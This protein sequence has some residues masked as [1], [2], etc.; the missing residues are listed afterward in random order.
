MRSSGG[1]EG[2]CLKEQLLRVLL[3]LMFSCLN[4][5]CIAWFTRTWAM[6][7]HSS[8]LDVQFLR[9]EMEHTENSNMNVCKYRS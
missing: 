7:V 4:L 1:V 3:S 8:T 6:Y 9:Y 2:V 5:R